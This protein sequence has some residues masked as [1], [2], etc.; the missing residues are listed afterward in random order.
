MLKSQ[1]K[2]LLEAIRA[3]ALDPTDFQVLATTLKDRSAVT[4]ITVR[5]S[6][7]YFRASSHPTSWNHW[8]CE[9][10]TFSPAFSREKPST[11]VFVSFDS[12]ASYFLKW[13]RNHAKPFIAEEA[14]PDPWAEI[15]RSEPFGVLSASVPQDDAPF[16]EAERASLMDGLQRF[17]NRVLSELALESRQL[18]LLD[19]RLSYLTE[20]SARVTRFDW[21]NLAL[22]S[23]VTIVAALSL[24]AEQGHRLVSLF[25]QAIGAVAGLLQ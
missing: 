24:N 15:A 23:L 21:L 20:A 13:L 7:L 25:R 5:R 4:V 10:V 1:K 12:L 16:T 18:A 17:R 6:R 3:E 14:L 8:A 19:E 9:W 22:S 2:I 11:S